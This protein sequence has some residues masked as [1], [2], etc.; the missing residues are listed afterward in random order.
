MS[1]PRPVPTL[2]D[3]NDLPEYPLTSAVRLTAHYFTVWWHDRWLSSDLCLLGS[4]EVKGVARDLFDWSQKQSPIGTLPDD[5]VLLARLLR[6]DL[7]HW[8]DLRAR[9]LGPLHGWVRC[10]TDRGVRL[11]HPVVTE[12]VMAAVDRREQREASNADKAVY[13]RLKRLR[14]GLIAL[15]CS[16]DLIRDDVLIE[17]MDQW[18]LQTCKGQRR[19]PVYARALEHAIAQGWVGAD[20]KR[21]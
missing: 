11:M 19:E 6:I 10:R 18:L 16:A 9:T 14:E 8:R 3:T 4:F 7:A 17:R 12:V 5:D 20:A 13:A 15:G 2:I 21:R 1:Q